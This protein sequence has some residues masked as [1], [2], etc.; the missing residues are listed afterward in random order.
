M[1]EVQEGMREIREMKETGLT[2]VKKRGSSLSGEVKA[3]TL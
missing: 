3:S 1:N 2:A